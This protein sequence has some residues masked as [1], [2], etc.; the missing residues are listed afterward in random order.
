MICRQA[1]TTAAPLRSVPADAAVAEVLGTLSVRVGMTRIVSMPTPKAVGRD[2]ADLGLQALTH[3][4]AAVIYLHAAIAIHQHQRARLIEESRGK[5]DAEF[6][7]VM[8]MP[9]FV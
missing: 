7:G 3:F 1:S 9:R 6:D 5:G 4:G 8:A 2:L